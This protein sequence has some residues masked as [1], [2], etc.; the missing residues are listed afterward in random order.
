MKGVLVTHVGVCSAPIVVRMQ[1]GNFTWQIM[2]FLI[3]GGR[4]EK[5]FVL[6]DKFFLSL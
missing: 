5:A 2:S 3:D 4:K 6:G 1:K